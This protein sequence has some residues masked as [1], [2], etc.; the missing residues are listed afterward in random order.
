MR[1]ASRF[2]ASELTV[3][4]STSLEV[5]SQ[6]VICS[7]S[8]RQVCDMLVGEFRLRVNDPR[9]GGGN[10]TLVGIGIASIRVVVVIAVAVN[11]VV[12]V[13]RTCAG[14]SEA[15]VD[16]LVKSNS[17]AGYTYR[18]VVPV[19]F[20]YLSSCDSFTRPS[21]PPITA[22][23]NTATTK[24]NAIASHNGSLPKQT[25]LLPFCFTRS[26]K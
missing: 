7:E 4:S 24:S 21:T 1:V 26:L 17:P 19:A 2:P 3:R 10:E 25:L 11:T 5:Q 13:G 20:E 8:V 9:G 23:S 16:K 18:I 15:L 12:A 22:P 6:A 14:T